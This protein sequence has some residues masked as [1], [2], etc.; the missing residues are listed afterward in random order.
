MRVKGFLPYLVDGDVL[1]LGS[2]PSVKSRETDFYYGNRQ[3]RFWKVLSTVF[4]RPLPTTNEE[5]KALLSAVGV[6]LWDVVTECEIVGSMDK[7]IK[8]PVIADLPDLLL[9][10][11]YKKILCNGATAYTLLVHAYPNLSSIAVKMPSTSP[12]NG[13]FSLDV[14]EKELLR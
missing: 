7:D 9:R 4:S 3:N 12:A 2:F 5:K 11:P 8:D 6:S 13:R 10:H 1:V 14:W